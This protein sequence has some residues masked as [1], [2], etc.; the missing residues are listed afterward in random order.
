MRYC[1]KP[2]FQGKESV[3]IPRKGSLNNVM[4]VSE[5]FWSVDT[6]FY[7]KMKNEYAGKYLYFRLSELNL[8]EMNSGSAVPSMTTDIL[9]DI[10]IPYPGD[11]LL[12]S[13]DLRIQPLFN[14]MATNNNGISHLTKLR[15]YLLPKLMSGEIN[16]STL[17][18]PTKYSFDGS[19]GYIFLMCILNILLIYHCIMKRRIDSD[20]TKNLLDLLYRHPF[21]YGPGCHSPPEFMWVYILY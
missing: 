21:I 4:F 8:A 19:S 11:E 12:Q 15:D 17:E 16:I 7:T 18:L 14:Q 6:M 13:F 2:L 5:P 9:N 3:L 1:E 20:V 10:E